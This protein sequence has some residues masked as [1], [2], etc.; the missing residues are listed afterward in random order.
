MRVN[1]QADNASHL[2]VTCP[3]CEADV[4][5]RVERDRGPGLDVMRFEYDHGCAGFE[6]GCE[7]VA[8]IPDFDENRD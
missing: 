3:Q 5:V 6:G 1:F 7:S 8:E 4:D 2:V